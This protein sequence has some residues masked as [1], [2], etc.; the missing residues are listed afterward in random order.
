MKAV[1]TRHRRQAGVTIVEVVVASALLLIGV[2]PILKAMTTAQ[3]TGRVVE[4]K[5]K[6]LILA[7]GKISEIQAR[8]LLSY[9]SNQSQ[10]D[11]VLD[12]HFL[13]NVSDNGH[14][15]LKTISVSVGHDSNGNGSLGSSEVMVTLTTLIA[16]RS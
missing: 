8:C 12:G 13:C 14:A 5:T 4:Q 9:D 3:V 11:V 7:Q 15:S 6:S 16:K 2:V 10:T 1:R